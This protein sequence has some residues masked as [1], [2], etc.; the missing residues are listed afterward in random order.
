MIEFLGVKVN[1]HGVPIWVPGD[2]TAQ[3][4]FFRVFM[5]T[6]LGRQLSPL[7]S[8]ETDARMMARIQQVHKKW[9]GECTE[10]TLD[11]FTS[12]VAS[13]LTTRDPEIV[14]PEVVEPEEVEPDVPRD[15][16]GK[17]LSPSQLAW[18]EHGEYANSHSAK[19]CRARAQTDASFRR[20]MQSSYLS[21]MNSKPV[22]AG[23]ILNA[24]SASPS[25]TEAPL[26]LREFAARYLQTSADEVRKLL[27]P[28]MNPATYAEYKRDLDAAIAAGLV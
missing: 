15:R 19:D 11:S 24:H 16:N 2:R 5:D 7:L 14:P 21:E 23:I 9:Y 22:D 6:D 1:E 28:V 3:L 20:F 17:I 25:P 26:R 13:L 18:K 27:S 8:P 4:G 10:I 12:V